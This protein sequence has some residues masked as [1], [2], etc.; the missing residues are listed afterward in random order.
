MAATD[1]VFLAVHRFLFCRVLN[2]IDIPLLR[3]DT[4][5]DLMRAY[6]NAK[7]WGRCWIRLN[8]FLVVYHDRLRFEVY[9]LNPDTLEYWLILFT[10]S[11]PPASLPRIPNWTPCQ[12][13]PVPPRRIYGRWGLPANMTFRRI[14]MVYTFEGQIWHS[15]SSSG[16]DSE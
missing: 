11:T 3:L 15:D 2:E 7:P 12:R 16:S 4:Q 8:G 14:E 5:A 1:A 10:G 9:R 13:P 6:P